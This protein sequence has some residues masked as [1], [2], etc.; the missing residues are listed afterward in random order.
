MGTKFLFSALL[1]LSLAL[2]GQGAASDNP[3]LRVMP[4]GDSITYG[5]C[6]RRGNGYRA[7]LYVAL[8]NLG[9]NVDYVGTQT[10]TYKSRTDPFL[11]DIDHEGHP[12]WQLSSTRVS[13]NHQG[14]YEHVQDYF[15]EIDDP[16]VILLHLGTNDVR[17]GDETFRREAT[18]RLVRLL[19]RIYECQPSAKVVVTTLMRR[20]SDAA[21]E[22]EA[23]NWKY[24]AI[25]NV[26]NPAVPGIVAAQ[27]AKGQS[28]YFLD[29]HEHLAFEHLYDTVHPNDVGYTNMANAWVSAVTSIV[30]DPA[31]FETENDLAVVRTATAK[32]TG[33][34]FTVDFTFNQKVASATA[35]DAANWTVAGTEIT[36]A[37]SL[38]ADLRTVTFDF[39]AGAY[40]EPVT[41][42]A[43]QSGVR[44]ATGGRTLH[45]AASRT[46]APSF[47]SDVRQ[48]VPDNLRAGYVPIYSLNDIDREAHKV[49]WSAGAPYDLDATADAAGGI[50]RVAYYFETVSLDGSTTNF[51]W[52]SFDSWTDDPTLLGVPVD[53][54]IGFG[55]KWVTNQDVYSNVGGVVNGTGMDGGFLEFW[56]SLISPDNTGGIPFASDETYDWGD[57]MRTS[58]SNYGCMQVHNVTN[59]QTIFAINDFMGSNAGGICAGIGN[60][61]TYPQNGDASK[62][63]H[64]D[65]THAYAAT[66]D[67]SRMALHILVKPKVN[68]PDHVI[69]NVPVAGN[70][71]LLYQIDVPTPFRVFDPEQYAAAHTA[72][73]RKRYAGS[74]V[75]RVGY[76]L[77]LTTTGETPETTWCW[78]AFDGF[79]DDLADYSFAT[80]KNIQRF[81]TN[82]DV[83][84]NVEG[85]KTGWYPDGNIEFYFT[86]YGYGNSFDIGASTASQDFDDVPSGSSAGYGCLQIH[87]YNEAQSLICI[88]NLK[89]NDATVDIG[90]GN[91]S[92]AKR[93]DWT[94]LGTATAYS[95]RRLYVLIAL[96]D[97]PVTLLQAVPS[98]DGTKVCAL[99][100]ENAPESLIDPVA[101]EFTTGEATVA[102]VTAS[103]FDPR[104]LILTLAQPLS[105]STSYALRCSTAGIKGAAESASV[106]FTTA[107]A[108]PI[109]SF[110]TPEA[111]PEAADYSLVNLLKIGNRVNYSWTGAPYQVD[112]SRFAQMDIDRVAYL[113]HLVSGTTNQWAWA[114]MDAFTDDVAKIGLPTKRRD[115]EFQ[116]YVANLSVRAWRS[117]GNLYV[118]TGDFDD[119][120]IEFCWHSYTGANAKSI[121][122]ATSACDWGDTFGVGKPGA[123]CLQVHNYSQSEVVLSVSN[124][125]SVP[126]T[127]TGRAALGIGNGSAQGA[128][129]GN[130]D[131]TGAKNG[132]KFSTKDL[133]VFVRLR[134][135][136][137]SAGDGPVFTM[138]PQ[139]AKIKRGM[140]HVLQAFAPGAVRYQWYRDGRP[141]AGETGASLSVLL[142]SNGETRDYRVVAYIDSENYTVSETATLTA[143]TPGLTVMCY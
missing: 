100:R 9:Y 74:H 59:Q 34:A 15:A 109:P 97:T 11:G 41:V 119:G 17:D 6:S 123:A 121:P 40:D 61:T 28:A 118:T 112:E 135:V 36:P 30:P 98:L 63:T 50:D 65:W 31:N 126:M 104:E 101:W 83:A 56:P 32:G 111:V 90:I 22:D 96:E 82:L 115:N 8:T 141:I 19:D 55:Q 95:V 42:T 25:T 68:T 110:L 88:N 58:S 125:G 43:K 139:S 78:A 46:V 94:T 127:D 14:I 7:P 137:E 27:Q 72:D 51:V 26:F 99:F 92:T 75:R 116:Q 45:S 130:D 18:N 20:W 29:M 107:A 33:G 120:N 131:W 106:S 124:T 67:Y 35:C 84:S 114:S 5:Y 48:H 21:G 89:G 103:P 70:Y 44:N 77:E 38:S 133:Y 79:T 53:A 85:V 117:D 4:L 39:P 93:R 66:R 76:Y 37:V 73:Y 136:T 113:L 1:A 24:A 60:N 71:E 142:T 105:P 86:S 102:A 91:S 143:Y 16:H 122:N 49:N 87:N 132:D 13:G 128:L 12:G 108:N 140:T 69:A 54:T 47:P 23:A 138:Q 52:T 129:G 2:S 3:V 62:P 134:V 64:P 81:V 57:K 80:N 10:E